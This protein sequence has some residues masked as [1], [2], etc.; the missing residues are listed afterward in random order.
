[1]TKRRRADQLKVKAERDGA[2]QT[3]GIVSCSSPGPL[4]SIRSPSTPR[5]ALAPLA[6]FPAPLKIALDPWISVPREPLR[7]PRL[8]I[9]LLTLCTSMP[10]L[11]LPG[12]HLLAALL[13]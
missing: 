2:Q 11:S 1:M 6:A 12:L 8:Q 10:I 5:S 4:L 13:S 3:L 7:F 9:W